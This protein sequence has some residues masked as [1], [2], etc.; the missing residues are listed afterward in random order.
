MIMGRIR[1]TSIK[2]TAQSIV[3]RD[4]NAPKTFVKVKE[5]LKEMNVF[6]SK[7]IRNKVAGYVV[8]TIKKKKF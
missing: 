1:H 5:Y 8:T 2:K 6:E 7:K 4:E 3:E